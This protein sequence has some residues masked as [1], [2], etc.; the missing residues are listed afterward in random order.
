MQKYWEVS[1]AYEAR[2]TPSAVVVRADGTVGSPIA[3]GAEAIRSLVQQ[4][5]EAPSPNAPLLP[6]APAPAHNGSGG[7]CPKCGKRHPAQDA[8]VI[9]QTLKV[10]EDASEMKLRG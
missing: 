1:G 7:P 9:P 6:G 2:G 8:P 5:A 3:G 4:V 10:D